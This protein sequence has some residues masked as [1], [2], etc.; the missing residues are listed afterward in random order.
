MRKIDAALFDVDGTLLDTA[1]FVNQ[2]F[3]HTFQTHGLPWQS[4]DE[5]AVSMGKPLEEMYR[6]FS[7]TEDISALCET[8]RSFQ[9]ENLHLSAPFANT[10][11]TLRR[12]KDAGIKIAAVTTRSRRT[13]IR[14]LEMGGILEYLDAVLSGEDA[15]NPKPHPESLLKAL[16]QLRVRPEKAAMVGD[17][18]ADIL[19]GREATVMT[20]GVSYGFHGSR[21]AESKPDFIVEDIADII[22]LLLSG[23]DSTVHPPR[24]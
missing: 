16:Q 6:R 14:T 23:H 17:T 18:D 1:E 11:E 13:S 8:H 5:I 22:P 3:A 24:S 19:A 20:I 10:Q 7:A 21:I 2:A 15:G 12:L 9:T 4:Y